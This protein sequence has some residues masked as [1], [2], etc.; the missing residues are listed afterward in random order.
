MVGNSSLGGRL[1]ALVAIAAR[2]V[3]TRPIDRMMKDFDG[4]DSNKSTSNALRNLRGVTKTGKNNYPHI[5]AH[6]NWWSKLTLE[7]GP[8]MCIFFLLLAV[9]VGMTRSMYFALLCAITID[10]RRVR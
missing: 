9:T 3:A 8:D 6:T 5:V 2:S 10:V 4:N 7:V 1:S